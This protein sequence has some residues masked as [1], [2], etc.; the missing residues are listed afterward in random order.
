MLALCN[1]VIP[2]EN[3]DRLVYHASSPDEDALVRAAQNL[4]FVFRKREPGLVVVNE[5][6]P[7]S[8]ILNFIGFSC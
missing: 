7:S 6:L 8:K 1:T 4:E 2:E 5:V 3:R